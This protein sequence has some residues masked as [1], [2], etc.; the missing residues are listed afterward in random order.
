MQLWGKKVS[1]YKNITSL[2]GKVN[3]CL[4]E[5][6]KGPPWG[7]FWRVRIKYLL[8]NVENDLKQTDLANFRKRQFFFFLLS[9]SLFTA[10]EQRWEDRG[11]SF[12]CIKLKSILFS[13]SKSLFFC[14]GNGNSMFVWNL[15]GIS[16]GVS[17]GLWCCREAFVLL[18]LLFSPA[19]GS[20][21]RRN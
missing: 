6:F 18:L 16:S 9:P 2:K 21:G 13:R 17:L 3:F 12:A 8:H 14:S 20:C 1:C 7:P 5:R 19:V 10:D 4:C 11:G 15:Q